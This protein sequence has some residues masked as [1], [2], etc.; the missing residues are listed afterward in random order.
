MTNKSKKFIDA[1]NWANE[2]HWDDL[3]KGTQIPYFSHVMSVAALVM[4]A[5]G[6]ENEVV[7]AL[8]HDT[9]E[10]CEAV[11]YEIIKDRYGTEIADIVRGLS[12]TEEKDPKPPWRERKEKYLGHL[13]STSCQST[14]LVSNADKLH[15]ARSI[16]TDLRDP[17]VGQKV[18]ERFKETTPQDS[19]WYYD[20]LRKIFNERSPSRRL[21]KELDKVVTDMI[22]SHTFTRPPRNNM[23]MAIDGLV[24]GLKDASLKGE[25]W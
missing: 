13:R 15:N 1:L 16:L 11:T 17:A 14:L 19:L 24:D 5:G 8:L 23:G 9:L 3:R 6:N 21:A 20:E 10:D 25:N 7:A 22:L 12:D 18:W 4:E 2:Q